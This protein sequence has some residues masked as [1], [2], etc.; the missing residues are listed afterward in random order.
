LKTVTKNTV[1]T[2][3]DSYSP[4]LSLESVQ[5]SVSDLI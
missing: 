4:I 3:P 1:C 2:V 5:N